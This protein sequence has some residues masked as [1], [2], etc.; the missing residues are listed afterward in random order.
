[1][2]C[3]S[4]EANLTMATIKFYFD[5]RRAKADGTFPLAFKIRHDKKAR[6][7]A[8]GISLLPEHWDAEQDRVTRRHPKSRDMNARLSHMLVLDEDAL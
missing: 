7:V 2:A 8:L 5:T 3:E 6:T 1:M 4:E